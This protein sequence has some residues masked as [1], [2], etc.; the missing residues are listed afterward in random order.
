MKCTNPDPDVDLDSDTEPD[1]SGMGGSGT[2]GSPSAVDII[3]LYDRDLDQGRDIES[4]TGS[5]LTEKGGRFDADL[6]T[7]TTFPISMSTKSS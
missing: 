7:V 1:G 3:R 4:P 5:M 2:G 6:P